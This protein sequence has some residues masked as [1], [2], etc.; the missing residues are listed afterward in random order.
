MPPPAGGSAVPPGDRPRRS[1]WLWVIV[2]TLVSAAIVAVVV[3]LTLAGRDRPLPTITNTPSVTPSST[4]VPEE[5]SGTDAP[6]VEAPPAPAPTEPAPQPT[7][8]APEPTEP[9]PTPTP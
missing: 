7:E 6:T 5:S 3:G 9:A 2:V 4:T 8:P 1:P